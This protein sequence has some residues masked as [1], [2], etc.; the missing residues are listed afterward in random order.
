MQADGNGSCNHISDAMALKALKACCT[1]VRF[2]DPA[3]QRLMRPTRYPTLEGVA[4]ISDAARG[5]PER[6]VARID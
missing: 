3:T 4:E 6:L 2:V 1:G 5:E